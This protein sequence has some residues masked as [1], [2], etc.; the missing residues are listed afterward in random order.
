MPSR[1]HNSN[2]EKPAERKFLRSS[3][4]DLTGVGGAETESHWPLYDAYHSSLTTTLAIKSGEISVD[5]YRLDKYVAMSNNQIKSANK[6]PNGPTLPS[7]FP[8]L[9]SLQSASGKWE[10]TEAVME[11]L[12][13]WPLCD[14]LLKLMCAMMPIPPSF[15]LYVKDM[16]ADHREKSYHYAVASEWE[17]ATALAL[18]SMRQNI[19]LF[20]KLADYHDAAFDYLRSKVSTDHVSHTTG[21]D[22]QPMSTTTE[23]SKTSDAPAMGSGEA[24]LAAAVKFIPE[25]KW[26]LSTVSAEDK[27][28]SILWFRKNPKSMALVATAAASPSSPSMEPH[29]LEVST[30]LSEES[31]GK[32]QQ[33]NIT[34]VPSSSSRRSVQFADATSSS[35]S[36]SPRKTQNH[37]GGA[38]GG[39]DE[40]NESAAVPPPPQSPSASPSSAIPMSEGSAR[41][42][43]L[44]RSVSPQQN[45]KRVRDCT[46]AVEELQLEVVQRSIALDQHV[47]EIRQCLQQSTVDFCMSE[48]YAQRNRSFDKLT[49]M[50]GDDF[51]PKAG[52]DDWRRDGVRGYRPLVIDFLCT[53]ML[54]AEARLDLE[55]AKSPGGRGSFLCSSSTSLSPSPTHGTGTGTGTGSSMTR[56]S[57]RGGDDGGGGAAAADA[58]RASR[59]AMVWD[60]Q[61]VVTKTLHRC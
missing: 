52:Y 9:L 41:L 59:W 45:A 18:A 26:V 19:D 51:S 16:A 33:P 1:S 47:M 32:A 30:S 57:R 3:K 56:R 23:D 38:R 34:T 37:N 20:D 53:V 24:L 25:A 58:W 43:E 61:D 42:N 22:K 31:D 35:P 7:P 49:A 44:L 12:G 29:S 17:V 11:C 2:S 8:A 4:Y 14:A 46:R 36:S 5:G 13:L 54:L 15:A 28:R 6:K 55:E 40:L 39:T 21:R 48:T 27:E 10:N 50:L 60:G